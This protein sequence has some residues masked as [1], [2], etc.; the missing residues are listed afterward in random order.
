MQ[1]NQKHERRS[2][3]AALGVHAEGFE[4]YPRI[5]HSFVGDLAQ[6]AHAAINFITK[7]STSAWGAT[8]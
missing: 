5:F 4:S 3:V 8:T 2:F 6:F 7:E 1:K